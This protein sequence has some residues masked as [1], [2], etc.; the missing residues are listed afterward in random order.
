L[1]NGLGTISITPLISKDRFDLLVG[2]VWS[3]L[4]N[5]LPVQYTATAHTVLAWLTAA[6]QSR[7]SI[8]RQ[9][10]INRAL[11]LSQGQGPEAA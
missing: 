7:F 3:S 6:L 5:T 8:S 11:A 4:W 1:A 10:V 9:K 2:K